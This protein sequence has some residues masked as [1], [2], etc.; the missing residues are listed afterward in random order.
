MRTRQPERALRT[1]DVL[2]HSLAEQS[3]VMKDKTSQI[4]SAGLPDSMTEKTATRHNGEVPSSANFSGENADVSQV[5]QQ[6]NW[7]IHNPLGTEHT[8]LGKEGNNKFEID[9]MRNQHNIDRS[10]AILEP[11]EA[12]VISLEEAVSKKKFDSVLREVNTLRGKLQ[13][14]TEEKVKV[15]ISFSKIW[16]YQ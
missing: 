11:N 4:K 16:M 7:Q 9:N 15:I 13:E 3:D 12:E 5:T 1:K 2:C 10:N 14:V 8:H 6:D